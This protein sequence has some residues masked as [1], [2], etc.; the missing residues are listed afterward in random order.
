M[1]YI[2]PKENRGGGTVEI[3]RDKADG[4]LLGT[5]KITASGGSAVTTPI[6]ASTGHHDLYLVFKNPSAKEKPM[7]NFGGVRLENR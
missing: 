3:H 2:D 1:A 7:F 4:P 6:E 5:V